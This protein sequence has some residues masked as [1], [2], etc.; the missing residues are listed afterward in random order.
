[1]ISLDL[2]KMSSSSSATVRVEKATS[3]LLLGPDWTLNMDICDSINSH[4]WQAKDV[5]KAVKKRLQH[6][7]PKVQFLALTLLETMVNNC[8]NDVHFQIIERDILQEMIKIVRK[9]TDMEV[10]DKI[11]SLLDSWQEAFGGAEGKYPQYYWAYAELRRSGV[12]FP[13]RSPDAPP[14]FT[15]QINRP[16]PLLQVPQAGYGMPTNSSLRLDEAMASDMAN[17]SLSDLDSMQ[18]VTEL[19]CEM[20]KAVN[21]DDRGAVKDEVITDLVSQCRS[22]QKKLMRL[23]NTTRDEEILGQ[24][25]ELNDNLQI[26]LA[27]HDAIASGSPMPT[28]IPDSI[29]RPSTPVASTPVVV[30][31]LE[32]EEEEED[33]EFAQLARR[34]SKLQ[35]VS[36]ENASSVTGDQASSNHNCATI[37]TVTPSTAAS[38][39]VPT[40]ALALPDPPAPVR[41]ATKEQDVMNLLSLALTS[42]PSP[43]RTPVTPPS[44]ANQNVAPASHSPNGQERPFHPQAYAVNQGFAPYNSYVAPWA[45][46]QPRSIP[47]PPQPQPQFQVPES[48][49]SYPP[50]PWATAPVNPETNHFSPPVYQFPSAPNA[51]AYSPTQASRPIQNFNSPVSRFHS[52]PAPAAGMQMNPNLRQSSFTTSL[53]PYVYSNRLF[54]ELRDLRSTDGSLKTSGVTP[55]SS[56]SSNQAMN[57]ERK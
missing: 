18:S 16:A 35:S 33:D 46:S 37:S 32:D 17:L 53:K 6:K 12:E 39:S 22:N 43:P 3:D 29:P 38:S 41:T 47:P 57:S 20:L 30:N 9:K 7:S 50:P 36:T 54:D 14:I 24:G 55:T 15:P 2:G 56:G 51:A 19:L 48:S 25:L 31:G 28:E 44:V 8:G 49:S 52:S 45:Q 40:N 21:P 10:R 26:L 13:Q 11:L 1:M 5:V 34:N 23:I 4:Q 27:K 42:N